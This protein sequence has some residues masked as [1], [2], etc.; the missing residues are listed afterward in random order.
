[1]LALITKYQTIDA[2]LRA[3]LPQ[4]V[5]RLVDALADAARDIA[6]IEATLGDGPY[7]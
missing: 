1:M 7:S 6:M 3:R 5:M 4:D 2:E